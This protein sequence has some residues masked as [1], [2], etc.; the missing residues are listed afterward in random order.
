M[1]LQEKGVVSV[2]HVPPQTIVGFES[3]NQSYLPCMNKKVQDKIDRVRELA[4]KSANQS[5]ANTGTNF[6]T[7]DSLSDVVRNAKEANIFL[8]ELDAAI[9]I[10]Q[11]NSSS[12]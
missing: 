8:E 11:K 10:A 7:A 12:Q 1:I 2:T 4:K 9:R 3:I 6:R 5:I